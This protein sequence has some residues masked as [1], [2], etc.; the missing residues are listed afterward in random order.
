[1]LTHIPPYLEASR[2]VAEAEEVFDRPVRLAVPRT[3]FTV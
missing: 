3:S 2:S 1:V